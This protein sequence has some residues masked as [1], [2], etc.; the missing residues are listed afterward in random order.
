MKRKDLL[1]SRN[2]LRKAQ[3]RASRYVRREKLAELPLV[4]CRSVKVYACI[5][6]QPQWLEYQPGDTVPKEVAQDLC[7]D[8]KR[9]LARGF[10]TSPELLAP[11]KEEAKPEPAPE[12]IEDPEDDCCEQE[13]CAGC[14]WT[15]DRK[16][17]EMQEELDARGIKYSS[18]ASKAELL[19]LLNLD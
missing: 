5:G 11:K 10:L 8:V 18:V 1:A 2:R 15:M 6:G 16:K 12:P 19:D 9:L 17:K 14:E 4:C 3:R 13:D 7:V